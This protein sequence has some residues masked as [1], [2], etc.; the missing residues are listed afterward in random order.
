MGLLEKRWA[1][2]KRTALEAELI[3][4][5]RRLAGPEVL[6]E[7]DWDGFAE[8]REDCGYIG[9]PGYGLPQLVQ[10]LEEVARDDLGREA[11]REKLRKIVIKPA[12]SNDATSFSFEGGEVVW[13]AYF[14]SYGTG[15]IYADAMQQTIEQGL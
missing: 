1:Q 13:L 2:E 15:Y 7:I 9:D 8:H 11:L 10:A 3:E 6:V 12:P 14:G 4:A 5:I